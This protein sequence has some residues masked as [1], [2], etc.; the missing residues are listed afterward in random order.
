MEPPFEETAGERPSEG[1]A[2]D[3]VGSL[4]AELEAQARRIDELSRAYAEVLN[5]REAFRKR[6]ERERDRQ[7]D[8]AKAA[9]AQIALEAMDE[10][11]RA[12][13]SSL[14]DPVALSEG[15]RLI[16]DG[17]QARLEAMGITPI[18]SEGQPF[19]PLLHEAVD[20]A[21]TADLASD[22]LVLEEVRG[23]WR[24]GDR[25]L[26]P[27]RVKVARYSPESREPGDEPG[28]AR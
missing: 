25:V 5:E 23:G 14:Q 9:S 8:A 27:T 18:P 11:R 12:R 22:G 6:L 19:D 24:M 3:E 13:G 2:P 20:L 16:A 7:I 28:E 15:V 10:L 4:Q 1:A 17:L 21:H 26:R